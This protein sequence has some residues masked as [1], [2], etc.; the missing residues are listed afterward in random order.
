M[1]VFS[2]LVGCASMPREQG[3]SD[4]HTLVDQ[5]NGAALGWAAD[6]ETETKTAATIQTLLSVPLTADT[7]VQ[8]ALL[9]NPRMQS[10][11]ARLGIAQADVFDASRISNPTFSITALHK[12]GEPTKFD[13]GLTVPFAELLMLPA[14]KRFAAGEYARTQQSIGAAILNLA[15]DTRAPGTPTSAPSKSPRCAR[16][17]PRPHKPRRTLRPSF[18]RPATS[19]FCN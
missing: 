2:A 4:I 17:S 5:R 14:R 15:S 11:Y 6:H 9:R 10:E 16:R 7:A 13:G 18:M 8:I 1:A 12:S 3:L 19:A